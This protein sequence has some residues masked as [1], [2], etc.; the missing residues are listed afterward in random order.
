M[1]VIAISV[2]KQVYDYYH[3]LKSGERSRRFRNILERH[4]RLQDTMH[5][6]DKHEF[7]DYKLENQ[8]LRDNIEK[9]QARLTEALAPKK[10]SLKD[11][12]RRFLTS[13]RARKQQDNSESE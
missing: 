10:V 3:S 2:S 11:L 7:H 5:S 4:L 9:L 6:Q 8:Q 1:P 13:N 12:I